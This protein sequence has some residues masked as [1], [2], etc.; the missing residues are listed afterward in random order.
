MSTAPTSYRQFLNVY[1]VWHPD[2]SHAGAG[3]EALASRR[4]FATTSSARPSSRGR[5]TSTARGPGA[6]SS[7]SRPR[8][9]CAPSSSCSAL[10]RDFQAAHPRTAGYRAADGGERQTPVPFEELERS[11][12][13]HADDPDIPERPIDYDE[14]VAAFL[15]AAPADLNNGLTEA[16]NLE[17]FETPDLDRTV[18]L[19]IKG[20]SEVR[21]R[22]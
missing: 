15:G 4:R 1:V 20:L 12:A 7:S 5:A 9:T 6:T 10:T 14:V 19:L 16:E 8:S 2:F 3:G 18:T 21:G 17:L 11:Y 13:A 22:A